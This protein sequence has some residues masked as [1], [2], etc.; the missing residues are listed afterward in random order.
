MAGPPRFEPAT[1]CFGLGLHHPPSFVYIYLLSALFLLL[2]PPIS[3]PSTAHPSCSCCCCCPVPPFNRRGRYAR[4]K[5][6]GHNRIFSLPTQPI[7]SLPIRNSCTVSSSTKRTIILTSADTRETARPPS[8]LSH[9]VAPVYYRNIRIRHR[10]RRIAHGS[11][12]LICF[13]IICYCIIILV[14]VH[15]PLVT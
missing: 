13:P 3:I 5:T 2:L 10:Y 7:Q 12:S 6:A 14:G 1:S 15:C 4:G 9:T 11:H 8:V